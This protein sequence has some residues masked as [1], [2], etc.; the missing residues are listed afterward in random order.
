MKS[1]LA[2]AT[3]GALLS[4]PALSAEKADPTAALTI[5]VFGDW[6]YN[7]L[8]LANGNLLTDSV[9]ADKAVRFVIHV[10]D[11]HSGSQP[12]TS[13]GILPP[14]ATSNPGWNQAVFQHFQQFSA[15]VVYTPGDNEWTDCHKSKEKAAGAPLNELAAVRGLFFSRPG[16]TLGVNEMDVTTQAKAFD[17]AHPQDAQFVENVIWEDSHIVFA[18]LNV[19]GS[20]DDTLPWTGTFAN[21]AAQANEIAQRDAA[22]LRWLESAFATAQRDNARALVLALQADMWD[23][24]AVAPGGDGLNA[25]TPFVQRLAQLA[26]AYGRPVL[27]L[28]GDSHLYE[29]DQPLADPTSAS[30]MIHHAP[31]VP[32][33]TRITVQGSTNA[34]AEWLRLTIDPSRNA[35]FTWTNVPYCRDPLTSCQ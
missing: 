26:L 8:L 17:P 2:A 9:N 4:F 19:P 30:G 16:V 22:N 31:A 18:T 35:P 25:Y 6:P 28:N 33:L 32:N 5:A 3:L 20:N 23:P 15:P 12:C 7:D 21:P 13:A 27:L 11:I 1:L 14:L 29:A 34:P 24:A 10:G